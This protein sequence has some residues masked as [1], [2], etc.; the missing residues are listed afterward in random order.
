MI[1]E[2]NRQENSSEFSAEAEKYLDTLS[3]FDLFKEKSRTLEFL[4]KIDPDFFIFPNSQNP[5]IMYNI[6][7]SKYIELVDKKIEAIF[8]PSN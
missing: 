1:A 7:P 3:I 4:L 6:N 2:D 5:R 8:T